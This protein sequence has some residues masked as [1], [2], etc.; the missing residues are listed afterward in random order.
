MEISSNQCH[1]RM[2]TLLLDCNLERR[3]C[4]DHP[5]CPGGSGLPV[6]STANLPVLKTKWATGF[7]HPLGLTCTPFGEWTRSVHMN[8]SP[9]VPPRHGAKFPDKQCI[10]YNLGDR[11]EEK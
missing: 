2:G 7:D 3:I 5:L 1:R 9:S 11:G 4:Q 8:R 6:I 10:V